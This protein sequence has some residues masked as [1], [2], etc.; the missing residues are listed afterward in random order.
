MKFIVSQPQFFRKIKFK[1]TSTIKQNY[2]I[3]LIVCL[4]LA[5]TIP[6]AAI[7][8]VWSDEVY[9]LNTTGKDLKYAINQAINFEL[10]PPLYFTLLNIWRT[11]NDSVFWA[12]LFSIIAIA[13]SIYVVD[14]LVKR[15]IKNINSLCFV[16][17]FVF[18]PFVIRMAIEIRVYAL[19]ILLS[20]L[21]L[22]F[23]HDGYLAQKSSIKS[24]VIYLIL[25]VSSLYTQYYLASLLIGNAVSL[26]VL[27]RWQALKYYVLGMSLVGLCISPIFF[28]VLNQVSKVSTQATFAQGNFW[29][30][31][32][33]G[34]LEKIQ[35]VFSIFADLNPPGLTII[36]L[37]IIL[38]LLGIILI[39]ELKLIS[40]NHIAIW[41][42]NITAVGFFMGVLIITNGLLL[43][44]HKTG[45]FIIFGL[46]LL[47]FLSL[48]KY[49][50]IRN[51][52]TISLTI[53]ALLFNSHDL[54]KEYS[55]LAKSGDWKRVA[56]YIMDYEQPNQEILVFIS[57]AAEELS[58]YYQG[59]NKIVPLPKAENFQNYAL[60]NYA[61]NSEAEII[62]AL[63]N[64][65]HNLW[66]VDNYQCGYLGVSYNCHILEDFVKKN[67]QVKNT[68]KFYKSRVRFL[69]RK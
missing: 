41:T 39:T 61:L 32:F 7:L 28:F 45:M 14:L 52:V 21:L 16:A 60:Q 22:L 23:F 12:R 69:Q 59:V 46:S 5:I 29:Q 24:R 11:V 64:N 27:R 34:K 18:N 66:L 35:K 65:D 17:I 67:Y 20:A 1:F 63:G 25:A 62:Q 3:H 13:I 33:V 31:F 43:P 48:I 10:Q 19:I 58:Y 54:Y 53:M 38:S 56:A 36:C 30:N 51:I 47:S 68:Q 40:A 9:S 8:N 49:S 26:L 44:R 37:F 42:I 2:L 6:L 55:I 50:Q 4:Y 57:I 15:F